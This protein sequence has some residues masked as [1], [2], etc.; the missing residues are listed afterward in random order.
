MGKHLKRKKKKNRIKRFFIL[1]ITLFLFAII[2][3]G[4]FTLYELSKMKTNKINDS[5]ENLG[6]NTNIDNKD[7]EK[8]ANVINI[9]LFGVDRR[10]ENDAARS[11]SIMILSVDKEHNK[12]KLTSIMRDTYVN[13]DNHGMTK[14]THAYA[15]GGPELAIKTINQNFDLDIR[16]YVTVDFF[17]LEK[18]IDVLGGV[19]INV[20]NSEIKYLNSYINEVSTIEKVTPPLVNKAGVQTLNGKQAVAY[21]R[22][23]YVGNGDYERTERQ[24][25][26]LSA[27][28]NKVQKSGIKQY[29]SLV[30]K[31]LPYTETSLSKLE[32]VKLGTDVFT[33]NITT[34]EQNRFPIDGY[35]QGETINKIWYLTTNLKTTTNHIHKYIYDDIITP[36]K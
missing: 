15:Y 24:R 35:C 33:N 36:A 10:N 18:I 27:L 20:K 7:K 23:R 8:R 16:D 6:I 4:L 28:F 17:S 25:T 5:D 32:I 22:I 11:D 26:V 34:I 3:G 12:I 13:V 19:Q 2:S 9:A 21:T 30:T 31:I 14:I 1:L 29:P